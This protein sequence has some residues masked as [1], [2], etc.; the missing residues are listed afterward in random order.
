[1]DSKHCVQSCCRRAGD[2][3]HLRTLYEPKMKPMV[4]PTPPPMSAPILM[5]IHEAS[6][7]RG[8]KE[9]LLYCVF[10]TSRVRKWV[11]SWLHDL[12]FCQTVGSCARGARAAMT[13]ECGRREKCVGVLAGPGLRHTLHS[14]LITCRH[15][16]AHDRPRSVRSPDSLCVLLAN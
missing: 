8:R 4:R 9:D 12:H 6:R 13:R 15:S 7:R 3:S 10:P 14:W 5:D 2:E 11:H 1:M 16:P